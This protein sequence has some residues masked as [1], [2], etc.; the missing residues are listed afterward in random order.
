MKKNNQNTKFDNELFMGIQYHLSLLEKCFK[1]TENILLSTTSMNID[2]INDLID[3][4]HRLIEIITK[5]QTNIE[6]KIERHSNECMHKDSISIVKSWFLDL[7]TIS[8][9][10]Q[11]IDKL[12]ILKLS[13]EREQTTQEISSLFKNKNKIKGYLINNSSTKENP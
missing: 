3:N 12:I 11:D 2:Q 9:Y 5:V 1:L 6:T 13:N 7:Q 4:R 8:S 10:I